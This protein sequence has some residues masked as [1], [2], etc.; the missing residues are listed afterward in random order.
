[1]PLCLFDGCGLSFSTQRG[2]AG[3][4]TAHLPTATRRTKKARANSYDDGGNVGAGGGGIFAAPE[5]EVA[6]LVLMP[7][8]TEDDEI[9]GIAPL[10][11]AFRDDDEEEGPVAQIPLINAHRRAFFGPL[12]L[13]SSEFVHCNADTHS[14]QHLPFSPDYVGQRYSSCFIY[15]SCFCAHAYTST[16]LFI[17]DLVRRGIFHAVQK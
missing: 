14:L 9:F 15:S 1:M 12:Y 11:D 5:V 6:V 10:D 16:F 4:Q 2:L 3:H 7:A 17:Y 8:V 13:S